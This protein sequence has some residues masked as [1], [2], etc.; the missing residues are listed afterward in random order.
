MTRFEQIGVERQ[1]SCDSKA[2]AIR[3]FEKSCDICCGKGMRIECDRC[4]I[5]YAHS[6]V[7]AYFDEQEIAKK[8]I[9]TISV[10]MVSVLR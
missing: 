6:L 9:T 4:S 8:R 5:S 7:V 2:E 10:S 3:V 1:R